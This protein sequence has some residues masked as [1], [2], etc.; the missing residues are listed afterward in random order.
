VDGKVNDVF[1]P[2]VTKGLDLTGGPYDLK[3]DDSQ[4]S[5]SGKGKLGGADIDLQYAAYLDLKNAP[6]VSTVKAAMIADKVMRAAFGVDIEQ[7]IIG[8]VPVDIDYRE[9][10]DKKESIVLKADL[11]PAVFQI[12][13][14]GYKK[15]IGKKGNVACNVSIKNGVVLKVSDLDI[16]VDK[17][18]GLKGALD[19]G[20]VGKINDVISGRFPNVTL[21]G[22]NDFAM[23]FSQK[24][25]QVYKIDIQGKEFDARRYTGYSPDVVANSGV[26]LSPAVDIKLQVSRLKTGDL[27]D[28]F[29][30]GAKVNVSTNTQDDI[31]DLSLT[32]KLPHGDLLLTLKPDKDGPLRLIMKS[33]NAGE[34]LY[35]MDI[36]KDMVGGKLEI[37]G[38]QKGKSLNDIQGTMRITDFSIVR[39]PVLAKLINLFSLSGM[40]ELLQN[41]GI[42]FEKMKSDFSWVKEGNKRKIYMR[43]G[44]MTG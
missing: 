42:S 9:G 24:Q 20:Q 4:F 41:K 40:S 16:R 18:G 15:D 7:F 23:N 35:A 28:Q 10:K 14:L 34:A 2:K 43:D 30:T 26:A 12:S 11:T 3:I 22:H 44:R 33:E 21:G 27:Q 17:D 32:G 19:F 5:F 13:P 38:L 6:Y 25:P 1:L 29:L 36:Y 31:T 8:A 39:A 37:S